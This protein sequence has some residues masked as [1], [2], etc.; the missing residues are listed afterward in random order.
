MNTI[1]KLGV[2]SALA[3]GYATAQA[4]VAYPSTGSSDLVLFVYDETN[5]ESYARDTGIS[6]DSLFPNGSI[7]GL[8]NTSYTDIHAGHVE[9]SIASSVNLNP[10]AN[11]NTFLAAKGSSDVVQWGLIGG[12][13]TG[14]QTTSNFN[15]PGQAKFISSSVKPSGDFTSLT[16]NQLTTWGNL[17]NAGGTQDYLQLNGNLAGASS[18]VGT[19]AST[20]G[21]WNSALGG[22]VM[23]N[24]YASGPINYGLL[25]SS[26]HFYA[27][28]GEGTNSAAPP[29]VFTLNDIVLTADGHLMNAPSAVPIPP[30]VWLFGT[31]LL[32]LVGVGRRKVLKVEPEGAAA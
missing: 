22:Q 16:V 2:G 6:I 31:G 15:T 7:N 1:L 24:W 21:V 28:T 23:T 30:A 5:Q 26:M 29:E 4:N 10:D 13:Y 8:G 3:L 18:I 25:G 32:G 19:G 17:G 9:G 20:H 27:L 12:Q 14:G 11:L